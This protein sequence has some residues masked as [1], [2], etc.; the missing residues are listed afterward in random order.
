MSDKHYAGDWAKAKVHA[1][2][3]QTLDTTLLTYRKPKDIHV[4]HF[5]GID[6]AETERVYLARGIPP[7]NII[8]LERDKKIYESI[9]GRNTGIKMHYG[10]LEDWVS[11]QREIDFDVVSLDY[12]GPLEETDLLLLIKLLRKQQRN[13]FILH[14]ANLLKREN[15]SNHYIAGM[16]IQSY[17]NDQLKTIEEAERAQLEVGKMTHDL[18]EKKN[19]GESIADIKKDS[20]T[21]LLRSVYAGMSLKTRRTMLKYMTYGDFSQ[22]S[23]ELKRATLARNPSAYFD[24]SDPVKSSG[25]NPY[26]LSYID[27]NARKIF[28]Y[29]LECEGIKDD[30]WRQVIEHAVITTCDDNK[31]F[32]DMLCKKYTYISESGS[33]MIGDIHFLRYPYQIVKKAR[34]VA[35]LVGFPH[36]IRVNNLNTL[37]KALIDYQEV[38]ENSRSLRYFNEDVKKLEREF[39]GNAAKPILTKKRFIQE[40]ESGHDSEYVKVHYRG[41]EGKPLPQWQAHF[42]MG[43][44]RSQKMTEESEDDTRVEKINKEQ[45]YD[46]LVSNVP[47][48]EIWEAYPTSF[49]LPQ[50][51]GFKAQLTREN[52]GEI[53]S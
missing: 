18:I 20:Y 6:M 16:A 3:G 49:T 12:T 31:N 41:W 29:Y 1:L 42:T 25:Y 45:V 7:Q 15:N 9:Q 36:E 13:S 17:Q 22:I 2:L 5:P 44:Y 53:S 35:R 26:A 50:L 19:R 8:G 52:N 4:L 33:P 30:G 27:L 51:R 46:Y 11:Q 34:E 10:T 38:A 23:E 24:I 47:P 14:H 48:Q 21:E 37:R 39:L 40:L 28:R 32:C 43:T